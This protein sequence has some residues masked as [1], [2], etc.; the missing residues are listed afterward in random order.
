MVWDRRGGGCVPVGCAC[1]P[2]CAS[3]ALDIVVITI[4]L[5]ALIVIRIILVIIIM[6]IETTIKLKIMMVMVI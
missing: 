5:V 6:I 3:P 2:R 1:G 4:I